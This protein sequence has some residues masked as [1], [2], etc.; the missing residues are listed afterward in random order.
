MLYFKPFN[1]PYEF[2]QISKPVGH[3][4]ILKPGEILKAEVIDIF[5]FG[6]IVIKA[7]GIHITVHTE[8]PLRK[9][10]QLLLKV[11]DS[12]VDKKIKLQIVSVLNK[13]GS[14][15]INP[16]LLKEE[17]SNLLIKNPFGEK[18]ISENIFQ[19]LP[20]LVKAKNK[21]IFISILTTLIKNKNLESLYSTQND[22][23]LNIKN[24]TPERLKDILISSGILFETKLKKNE[25][26]EDI[27]EAIL[28]NELDLPEI[29]E[30][31]KNHQALSVL[32]GGLS[33]FI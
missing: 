9:N 33:F 18:I 12:D 26:T 10:T 6:G 13:D 28:K 11:M 7:K 31:I 8:I 27:K 20:S 3:S 32:T 17:I 5:P 1:Y 2:L 15:Q 14:V 22:F 4:I 25:K 30:T 23:F 19:S 21:E 29:K 16:N 24:L